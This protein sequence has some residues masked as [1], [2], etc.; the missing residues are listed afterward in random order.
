MTATIPRKQIRTVVPNPAYVIVADSLLATSEVG[1]FPRDSIYAFDGSQAGIQAVTVSAAIQELA[2]LPVSGWFNTTGTY[3]VDLL[4]HNNKLRKLEIIGDTTFTATN[5]ALGL[6]TILLLKETNVAVR[7]L[8]F[9]PSWVFAN[10]FSGDQI[11]NER[12][13]LTIICVSPNDQEC[14]IFANEID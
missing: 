9:P 8:T 5:Y 6:K 12:L 1:V 14:L 13:M 11:H 4:A 7:N 10:G 3:N 2:V